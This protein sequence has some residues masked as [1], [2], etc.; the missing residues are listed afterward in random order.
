MIAIK[1][2]TDIVSNVA[3]VA[4]L[5][6]VG[7][8]TFYHFVKG[9]VFKP[10]LS[11]KGSAHYLHTH[12]GD[13][14]VCSITVSNV[15]L[16]QVQKADADVA[17]YALSRNGRQ[18]K[19]LGGDKILRSHEW[20]EPG[21]ILNEQMAIPRPPETAVVVV[22]FRVVVA[23]KGWF[24]SRSSRQ[25]FSTTIVEGA[26]PQDPPRAREELAT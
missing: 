2:F 9:R 7:V 6:I 15:G 12:A 5:A 19:R 26:T 3:T 17:V 16:S 25:S 8:W 21:A 22:D 1:D 14:V 11:L 24:G 23:A 4:G 13:Y 10:R 20:V 18:R